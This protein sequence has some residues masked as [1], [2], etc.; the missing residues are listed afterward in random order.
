MSEGA[1]ILLTGFMASGKSSVAEALA[2]S[3]DCEMLDLDQFIA[4]REGRSIQTIIN[5]DGEARFRQMEESALRE[6]LES[7]TARIIALGGGTWMS[8]RNR[9]LIAEN[10]CFTVWLDASFE[11][12][13]QRIIRARDDAPRPLARDKKQAGRL[14]EERRALYKLAALRVQINEEADAGVI[15]IKIVNALRQRTE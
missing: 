11:L 6:A 1:R 3:L 4:Q 14:Y 10:L 15:A 8:P 7:S 9:A 5:E 12:C 2:R 13:W